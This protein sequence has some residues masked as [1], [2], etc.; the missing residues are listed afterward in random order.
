MLGLDTFAIANMTLIITYG[1][2]QQRCSID[3]MTSYKCSMVPQFP[4]T[5][6][7]PLVYELGAYVRAND[8]EQQS[9]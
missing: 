4:V 7:L 5:G 8:I 6:V 2:R 1:H 9:V 3:H